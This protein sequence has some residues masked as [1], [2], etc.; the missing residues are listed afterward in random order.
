MTYFDIF[1]TSNVPSMAHSTRIGQVKVLVTGGAG[2][3]GG[4]L[5]NQVVAAGH[6]V[7][8]FDSLL[9]ED[10]YLKQVPFF[11]GDITDIEALR[12]HL[13]W[14]DSVVFLAGFVGD[15]LCALNPKRT[16]QVNVDAIKLL[17]ENFDGQIVFPS[18][19]S[20]YGAQD[21]EL[22]EE[23]PV[24]PLSLYAETKIVA[25]EILK[26]RRAPAIILRLGTLFGLS[27]TYSRIRVD[28]VL[29][30]LTVR[31]V[32]DKRMSVFGG[33]QFRP[34]LHV[35]D[36][37]TAVVPHLGSDKRGIYNLHS[38]NTTIVDL[39][40]RIK[41]FVP[42]AEIELTEST[43]QDSRNYMVSSMK[44]RVELG[45]HPRFSVDDGIQEIADAVRSRRIKNVHLPR[46]SNV[47][48][49]TP[50]IGENM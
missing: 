33:N 30:V 38:E 29:N 24:S 45:F 47:A 4:W 50:I 2:Y 40:R 36:V 7:R 17:A 12:V 27:D 16:H 22:T 35:R 19:C 41:H 13:E 31:A 43:F 32:L 6:E 21:G 9:Y 5:V 11:F 42:D 37:A 8:V 14:A 48:A 15:P 20:V 28:L 34:L 39:A 46:F 3:V 26:K 18:S 10:L 44:A 25:E 49:M 23:S 1:T